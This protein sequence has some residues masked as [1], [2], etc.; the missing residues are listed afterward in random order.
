MSTD[1]AVVEDKGII[2]IPFEIEIDHPRN[3]DVLIQSIVGCRLRSAIEGSRPVK[4]AKTGEWHVP[5][6]QAR[7]LASFPRTP[8]QHL[9]VNPY[10]LTYVITD[11][12]ENDEEMC[13]KILKYLK[14]SG[15]PGVQKVRGVARTEGKLDINRMK[16]LC[17]EI[18]NLAEGEKAI[19]VVK[20]KLPILS[21]VD[22]LPGEYL[23]NPGSRVNNTQPQ[24]E[25]EYGDW[26][27]RLSRNG[28]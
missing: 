7:A 4:D 23:L 9:H 25:S 27:Q 12:L 19:K 16:T 11:P 28:G 5:Q 1:S 26:V 3:D 17:R 2:V 13:E 14:K 8:G 15:S 10:A 22:M 21:D 18:I 6:D 20:G 24:F